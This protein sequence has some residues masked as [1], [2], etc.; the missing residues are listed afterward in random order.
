MEH[1]FEIEINYDFYIRLN[2]FKWDRL[3]MRL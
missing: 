3:N 1:K 2:S